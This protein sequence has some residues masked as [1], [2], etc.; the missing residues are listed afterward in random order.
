MV[1]TE[2]VLLE[3]ADGLAT[4]RHR[5]Q[6][7]R[8]RQALLANPNVSVVALE[9]PLYEQGLALYAARADKEW[10]LTDC[11]SFLVM[12]RDGILSALTADH[13][14]E[15]AGFVALLK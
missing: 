9:M 3:L 2:W 12:Q 1:T 4:S 8:T 11:I 6:L 7:A 10:T 15:Q 13:H 5:G 14:F